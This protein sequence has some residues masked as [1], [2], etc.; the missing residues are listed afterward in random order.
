M[1]KLIQGLTG[2]GRG[3]R[4]IQAPLR[5]R[6]GIA[7]QCNGRLGVGEW[8]WSR[9]AFPNPGKWQRGVDSRR[10][11]GAAAAAAAAIEC[12]ALRPES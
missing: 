6:M 5:R 4:D 2:E 10:G 7:S 12:L 11:T 8:M 1:T 9:A 3:E